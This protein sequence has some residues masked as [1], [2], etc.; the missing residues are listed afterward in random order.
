MRAE[1]WPENQPGWKERAP[2]VVGQKVRLVVRGMPPP[3]EGLLVGGEGSKGRGC[4][5]GLVGA[6]FGT[7]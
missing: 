4:F 7:L 5:G 2:P 1:E 6:L 3:G